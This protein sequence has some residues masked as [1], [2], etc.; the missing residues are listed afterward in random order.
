V[1]PV[2][3]RENP[4][5]RATLART[6]DVLTTDEQFIQEAVARA[7][8]AVIT[9]ATSEEVT[10]SVASLRVL[11][12]AVL[13]RVLRRAAQHL[14]GGEPALTWRH[15]E[16]LLELVERPAPPR[17]LTL[18]GGVSARVATDALTLARALAAP[19]A[20]HAPPAEPAAVELP[21]PGCVDVPGTRWRVC[22]ELLDPSAGA[23]PPG[24][25]LAAYGSDYMGRDMLRPSQG[26]AESVGRA[27]MRAYLD[28]DAV[29]LP[30]AVRTWRPGDRFRPLGMVGEKKLQDYFVD[31]RIPRGE[32]SAIPLVW[33]ARH[34]LWVAGHRLDNRVR[35]RPETRRVLAL[36][37][38]PLADGTR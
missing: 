35:M 7:W 9:G 34:L 6:A 5:L 1:L 11:H 4:N 36:R 8:D 25:E 10:L 33:G 2:L 24:A 21:I 38:E 31:A 37:L 28:A 19:A 30:L 20:S 12:P 17:H 18:S 26:T 22:A 14:A 13:R 3:L 27:Q 23:A 29:A 32:R 16:A 15:V